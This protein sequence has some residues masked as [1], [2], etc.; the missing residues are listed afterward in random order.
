[1]TFA[2]KVYCVNSDGANEGLEMY[3]ELYRQ[4][5]KIKLLL[6]A[7][8]RTLSCVKT[9]TVPN[10]LARGNGTKKNILERRHL[11]GRP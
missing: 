7:Q 5:S 3:K 2:L 6:S 10:S 11:R 8:N 1:M 9:C 4:Q